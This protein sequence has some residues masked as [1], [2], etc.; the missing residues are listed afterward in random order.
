MSGND[1]DWSS[2]LGAKCYSRTLYL[3]KNVQGVIKCPVECCDHR[4]FTSKRGCRKHLHAKHPW[5]FYFDDKPQVDL[6]ESELKHIGAF[7]FTTSKRVDTTKK[8]HFPINGTICEELIEWLCAECGG[9]MSREQAKIIATRVMKFLKFC[10]EDND[11]DDKLS[12]CF[13]DY[14]LGSPNLITKFIEVIGN[15]WGLTS[16]AKINYLQSIQ[17][18]MDFRKSQGITDSVRRNFC[19]TDV[20][21]TRGKRNLSK[22]K[23]AEWS[24]DLDI[25]HLQEI[26][27]WAT[28]AEL[29]TVLPFHLPK[30]N[31]ILS[32]CKS[33][34]FYKVSSNSLTFATRFLAVF[35]FIHV[36]GSRPMTYQ[37]LTIGMFEK[38]RECDGFIDQTQFK[39]S[40]QYTFDSVFFDSESTQIVEDYIRYIRPLFNPKCDYLLVTR[41]GNQHKKLSDLMSILVFQAIGKYIHPTRY[42]QIVETES[43]LRLS[44][45]EQSVISKD[46]KHSSNVAKTYYQKISSRDVAVKARKCMEK[47]KAT[48]NLE[49][50]KEGRASTSQETEISKMIEN[51]S[52]DDK[53]IVIN[54]SNEGLYPRLVSLTDRQ[55]DISHVDKSNDE[56]ISRE[57]VMEAR[58]CMNKVKV[59]SNL[60]LSKEDRAPTS[61]HEVEPDISKRQVREKIE[62][63]SDDTKIVINVSNK[64]LYPRQSVT[65]LKGR[66]RK[67]TH[68]R[69]KRVSFSSIE[70]NCLKNGII[71][72]GHE[73]WTSILMDNN[74]QF[75]SNRTSDTLRKRAKII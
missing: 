62:N 6:Q 36:K 49:I 20:Y 15:E 47:L 42:R 51:P 26:N 74:Y 14:C 5:Y 66:K 18:M 54:V 11:D 12:K 50:S 64:G 60:E 21:I 41:N 4:G 24:R 3:D 65:S 39:T 17:D 57:I 53:T 30:Y 22:K 37:Y 59:N 19:I 63:P 9:G 43:A 70:D 29:Q 31:D 27:S 10:S 61:Q 38:S 40:H 67:K 71:K 48:S 35:L 34:Q 72:H 69:K 16:S 23:I 25:N 8:P 46:Q 44:Q 28:L 7:K 75:H 45:E 68:I 52:S 73:N 33:G 2:L 55:K 13:V 1:I 58:N 56:K 32:L